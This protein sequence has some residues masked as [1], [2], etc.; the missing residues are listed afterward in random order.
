MDRVGPAQPCD[1]GS[2][3]TAAPQSGEGG[4]AGKLCVRGGGTE[5]YRTIDIWLCSALG[6]PAGLAVRKVECGRGMGLKMGH[7]GS[8]GPAQ[9]CDRGSKRTA[10]A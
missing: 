3:R 5:A 4:A 10:A 8:V 6:H 1:R 7:G 9:P 2:K